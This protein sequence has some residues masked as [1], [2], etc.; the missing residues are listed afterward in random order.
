M[1]TNYKQLQNAL[2]YTKEAIARVLGIVPKRVMRTM[3]WAIGF[4]IWIKGKR[5]RL[6]KKSLFTA[7]FAQVRKEKSKSYSVKHIPNGGY[8]NTELYQVERK[9]DVAA[10]TGYSSIYQV[11]TKTVGVTPVYACGCED[12]V[13]ISEAFRKGGACKH[14]YAVLN[15]QGYSTLKEAIDA[16]AKYHSDDKV[17]M[18]AAE[19]KAAI[20]L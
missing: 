8:S 5:P 18:A 6:Y 4:W 2:I 9:N 13:K 11:R 20:G 16:T 7:S 10:G 3:V 15:Y 17:Q 19:A 1:K 12:Y 14:I